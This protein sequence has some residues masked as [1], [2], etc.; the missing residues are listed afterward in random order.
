LGNAPNPPEFDQHLIGIA[1]NEKRSFTITYPKDYAAEEM[2]SATVDYE[3]TVKSIRKKEL[4][5]LD[6]EFAKEVSELETLDAL[7]ERI[8]TDL[9]KEAEHES[10][11]KMR[12][13][14]LHELASRMK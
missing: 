4:L 5:P 13:E 9:Q 14:L 6:D 10:E 2:A 11:H 12:H 3:V 1:L 8:K 7:R